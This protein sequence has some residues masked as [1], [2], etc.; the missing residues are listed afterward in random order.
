MEVLDYLERFGHEQLVYCSDPAAGLRAII[1]IH[2]TTLGPA[3][4]GARMWP[5]PSEEAATIDVLRLARAMTYKS[6]AAGL[7]LG[8][9][10]AVIIADPARDKTEALF[11]SFGRFV[12]S[13]GGRY[14]TTEDVGTTVRD[15]EWVAAETEYVT[16]LPLSQGGSGDPSPA[17]A[18]GVFQAMR[19]C[20][21]EA[22]GSDSLQGR[23]VALQGCGKVGSYLAGH[24]REAGAHLIACDVSPQA[25]QR[26][27]AE[28][29]ASLVPHPEIYDVDCDIFAPCALGG[30]LNDDT[31]PRLRAPI[32][33]GGAN[34][35][36]LEDRHAQA[37]AQRGILYAPDYVANAGGVINLSYELTGY[38]EDAAHEKVSK[39]YE[40]MQQVI[41]LAKAEGTTTAQAADSLAE[42]RLAAARG[43]RRIY[44][45]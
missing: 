34:N 12:N 35:Q 31:I 41:A 7:N 28:F 25:A 44:L 13:L 16:G 27:Q 36:L 38:D 17:T 10:K 5:F 26:A 18:F 23:R 11:R 2:D 40:S 15:M 29:G 6:A 20:A 30:I 21:R 14:I 43:I 32:V 1:A 42:Q 9:G 22:L 33:C 45:E 39:I 8:G 19:A 4:G 3:L 24:L 37:L